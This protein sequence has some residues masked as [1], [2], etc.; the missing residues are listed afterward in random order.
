MFLNE[1]ATPIMAHSKTRDL[2]EK[3]R[4]ADIVVVAV[5]KKNFLTEDIF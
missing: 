4:N 5:G 3:T 2:A 1:N